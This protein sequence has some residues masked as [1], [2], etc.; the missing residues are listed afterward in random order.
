M[1]RNMVNL[2]VVKQN[3]LKPTHNL[4]LISESRKHHK[5]KPTF[6]KTK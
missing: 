2:A 3:N 4:I 1:I 6:K 5:S